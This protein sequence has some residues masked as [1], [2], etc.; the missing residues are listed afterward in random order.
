M[1]KPIIGLTPSHNLEN[2]RIFVTPAYV[3]ALSD[4]GALCII[5]P[6]GASKEDLEHLVSV[7]DGILFTGGPD[8]HPF[9]FGEETLLHCGESSPE[10]DQ[11]EL[12]LLP[13]VMAARKPVL[14]VCRGAQLINIALGGDIYQ[15]LESQLP[16][17][18]PTISHQQPFAPETPCHYVSIAKDSLLARIT[19]A[20]DPSI[21]FKLE[22]NSLHHQAIRRL[23]PGL[24]ACAHS[25]DGLIEAVEMPEYPFLV[26]VQWHPEYLFQ[27]QAAAKGIFEGFVQACKH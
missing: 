22:V 13:L 10:R 14:G 16:K 3:K 8:V 1:R 23:A 15:D 24:T 2:G 5:L 4:A 19:G 18:A 25:S 11:L 7:C 6:L 17:A 21:C 12:N 20:G 27:K 26:A 9:F